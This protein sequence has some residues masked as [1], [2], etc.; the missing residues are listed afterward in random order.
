MRGFGRG[1]PING[2]KDNNNKLKEFKFKLHGSGKSKQTVTSSKVEDAIECNQLL[3]KV[4]HF[5]LA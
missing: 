3:T 5:Q 4:F 2:N 1:Q